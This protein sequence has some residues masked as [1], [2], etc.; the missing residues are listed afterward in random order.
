MVP[1]GQYIINHRSKADK[2]RLWSLGDIHWW[3]KACA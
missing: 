3:N 2:F 1:G